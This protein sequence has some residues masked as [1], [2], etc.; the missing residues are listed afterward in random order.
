MRFSGYRLESINIRAERARY[1]IRWSKT[2]NIFQNSLT[3]EIL[4]HVVYLLKFIFD[5]HSSELSYL[6]FLVPDLDIACRC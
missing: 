5:I 2:I 6:S 3:F 1:L 4:V